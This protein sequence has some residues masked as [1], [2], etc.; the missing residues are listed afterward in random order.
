MNR[1]FTIEGGFTVPDGT[2]VYPF[3]NPK[4]SMSGLPWDLVEGFS[5]A[6]GDMAPKSKSKIQVLPLAS[7]VRLSSAV[8]WRWSSKMQSLLSRT[9]FRLLPSKLPSPDRVRSFNL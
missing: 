8:C 5:I 3:L 1:I 7:Q 6:A 9:G 2:T 4:D